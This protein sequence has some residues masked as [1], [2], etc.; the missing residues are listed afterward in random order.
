MTTLVFSS[1]SRVL[2]H[3]EHY[4]LR[5]ERIKLSGLTALTKHWLR[6]SRL[7]SITSEVTHQLSRIHEIQTGDGAT[8]QSTP[9][10]VCRGCLGTVQSVFPHL[11]NIYSV[12]HKIV[13]SNFPSLDGC[14][15]LYTSYCL[16]M[17]GCIK[18]WTLR[19]W[20]LFASCSLF[21]WQISH[22]LRSSSPSTI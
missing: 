21:L 12:N 2:G 15:S 6:S 22:H 9:S 16:I 8:F 4:S 17:P 18:S 14:Q 20:D 1:F 5:A 7:G 10:C 19:S 13:A 3:R 11:W